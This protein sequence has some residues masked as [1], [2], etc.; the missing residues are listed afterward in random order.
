MNAVEELISMDKVISK[1]SILMSYLTAF[2]IILIV[3]ISCI[4]G[5]I[6]TSNPRLSLVLITTL[7]LLVLLLVSKG[8]YRYAKFVRIE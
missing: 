4:L 2:G 7:E 5:F 6:G 1:S 3:L 8:V